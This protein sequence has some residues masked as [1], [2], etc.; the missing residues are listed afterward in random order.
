MNGQYLIPANSKKAQLIFSIFRPE[1][2]IVLGIGVT[3]TFLMLSFIPQ[4]MQILTI[5][6]IIPGL[7][8]GFL[9]LPVPQ[10]HNVMNFLFIVFFFFTKQR[11]YKWQGWG[12]DYG[13]EKK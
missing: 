9:V 3:A 6:S 10:Y 2:L 7:L 4:S 5:V 11:G 13:N 1:D 8:A 12:K